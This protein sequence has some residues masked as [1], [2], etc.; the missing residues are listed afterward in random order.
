[1]KVKYK[2]NFVTFA[3]VI[4]DIVVLN[5]KQLLGLSFQMALFM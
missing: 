3:F 2:I 5:K 4:A 1:M